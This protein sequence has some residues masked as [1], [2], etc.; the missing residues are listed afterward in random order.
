[1]TN[2]T[3]RETFLVPSFDL[4]E[5]ERIKLDRFLLLLEDSGVGELLPERS[6]NPM[7]RPAYR[8]ADLFAVILCGFAFGEASLRDLEDACK[9]DL[10]FFYLMQQKRPGHTVFGDFINEVILPQ[11][12]EI[13]GRITKAIIKETGIEADECFIDGSKFEADANRYKF[14][15]KPVKLHEKLSDKIR[16]LLKEVSLERNVPEKG[17]LSSVLIA[18]KLTKLSERLKEDPSLK[19][20]FEELAAYLEKLLEY[21]EKERICGEDR[22]S[23]FK[24]DHDATAMTMKSD[25]YSGL[26]SHMRAA[27]N[28]QLL[29]SKGVICA[30]HVSQ[31][32]SDI[33]EFVPVLRAF[34]EIYGKYPERVCADAGYGSLQNYQFLKENKIENYIKPTNFQGNVSGRNP[35]CYTLQEDGTLLCL[36]G[37]IGRGTEIPSRHSKNAGSVFYR[38]EDCRECPFAAYCKRFLKRKKDSFRIFEV[39]EELTFYKQEAFANLLSAKGIEM[40]VNRSS[41]VEGAF[42]V[43]KQ[44]MSYVRLRRTS[45]EKAETEFMLTALG[46]NIRKLFR[47]FSGKASFDY[48]RAPEGLQAEKK[49]KPSAKR[50]SKRASKKKKRSVNDKA[51]DYR[52]RSAKKK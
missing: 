21:E 14:V 3:T 20:H 46:Y 47:F 6:D 10:R 11:R 2:F 42:G 22:N 9:Y 50:L 25:Y 43:L 36:G 26:G 45:L 5:K 13:F 7:G 33:T 34:E 38:V 28:V 32:R 37:R 44:D 8:Y 48:W 19:K 40:R 24:S 51:K 17:P 18:G 31:S 41:Q 30:Y 23:Y 1:M 16:D 49:R 35:D 52:Y 4:E 15:W 12:K 29:V 39:Q 27:Y